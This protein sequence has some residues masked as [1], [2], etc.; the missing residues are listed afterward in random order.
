MQ[1]LML[2]WA[3]ALE[4][5][6]GRVLLDA[7]PREVLFDGMRACGLLALTEGSLALEIR[8]PA[9]VLA[10]PLPDALRWLAPERIDPGLARLA[11]ALEDE[12]ADALGWFAGVRR[13]PR[14]RSTGKPDEYAGWNRLLVGDE[15]RYHGGFH[16]P[17]LGSRAAAPPGK[18]LLHAYVVRWLRRDERR[19]WRGSAP[20]L[21]RVVGYLRELYLDFEDCVEWSAR[22]WVER[23]SCMA[24]YWAPVERHGPRAPGCPGVYLAGATIESDSGP[25]DVSAHA[26]LQVCEA[27]ARDREGRA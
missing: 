3:Q 21:E 5:C 9:V 8:A 14:L 11:R 13:L 12:S 22:Q 15:R 6:G 4:S 27:L 24:W 2:P 1:G 23:P 26:A 25:V 10:A 18:H 17:S 16:L 19:D 7:A 20:V